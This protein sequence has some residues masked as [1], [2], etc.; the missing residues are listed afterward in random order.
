M[1]RLILIPAL[2]VVCAGFAGIEI[3]A[4]A[5]QN[6]AQ[7]VTFSSSAN[8]V[9]ID[10]NVRD[11]SGKVI[12]DLKKSDFTVLEDG[13]PQMVSVFE[14]QRLEG[15]TNLAPVPA[16]K[17]IAP[18]PATSVQA[19]AP[20]PKKTAGPTTASAQP[21]IRYQDRRLVA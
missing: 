21:I 20:A 16:G 5:Q 3:P 1:K 8:L 4:A 11:K 14:F 15:D 6:N 10:A 19:A 17:P 2:A 9:V 13:K 7:D 12:P 18:A